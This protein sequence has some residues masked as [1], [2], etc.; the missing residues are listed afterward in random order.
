[1]Y[2]L[3]KLIDHISCIDKLV[4]HFNSFRLINV[5][6]HKYVHKM[7][8]ILYKDLFND[9]SIKIYSFLDMF[10]GVYHGWLELFHGVSRSISWLT[11]ALYPCFTKYIMAD[12]NSISVHHHNDIIDSTKTI[13]RCV[14]ILQVS[15]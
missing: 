13:R 7:E 6:S 8:K 2:I 4:C 12:W 5:F 1:M 9:K 10:Y 11:A 14:P 15:R 3:C